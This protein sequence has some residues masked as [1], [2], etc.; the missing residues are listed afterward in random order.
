[1]RISRRSDYA[2]R[3]MLTLVDHYGQGA[4]S[5]S[6]LARRNDIPKQFLE[7]IM[8]DLKKE[9][10]VKSL[11]GRSGGYELA[12]DPEHITMGQ[13]IRLFDGMLAPIGCVSVSVHEPCSQSTVC[14]FRRVLLDIRNQTTKYLESATLAKVAGLKPVSDQEVFHLSFFQGDG[15]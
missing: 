2:L 13:I 12:K 4:M 9:A 14:R 3:A 7:H 5:L 11:P 10:W 8:L 6:E 15:I 1:M